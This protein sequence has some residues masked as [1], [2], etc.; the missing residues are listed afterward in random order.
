MYDDPEA[1]SRFL[2]GQSHPLSLPRAGHQRRQFRSHLPSS[3]TIC[4]SFKLFPATLTAPI[5]APSATAA[6]TWM[7]FVERQTIRRDSD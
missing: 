3:M 7:S 6:V 1:A 5:A 4:C 2:F